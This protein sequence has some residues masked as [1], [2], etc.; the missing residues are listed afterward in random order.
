MKTINVVVM[1]AG[2]VLV[3]LIFNMKDC[4]LGP[5]PEHCREK[6][7]N[8]F[9]TKCDMFQTIEEFRGELICR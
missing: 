1:I 4:D 5:S 2:L 8:D 7:L 3:A 6:T 9:D